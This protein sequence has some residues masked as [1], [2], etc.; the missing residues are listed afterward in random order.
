[1]ESWKSHVRVELFHRDCRQK[2]P[3]SGL[4][5]KVSKLEEMLDF[6]VKLWQGM[7][8]NSSEENTGSRCP[9][10]GGTLYLRVNEMELFNQQVAA[11]GWLSKEA[12]SRQVS[13]TVCNKQLRKQTFRIQ[14][15]APSILTL[16]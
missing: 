11:F 12:V 2:D 1:M 4:F 3:F 8:T 9:D 6:H 15:S 10:E 14:N 13:P 7:D 5:H 16:T